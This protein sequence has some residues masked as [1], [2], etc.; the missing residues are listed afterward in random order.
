[1][2][3]DLA[4]SLHEVR[5]ADAR[6]RIEFD[7]RVQPIRAEAGAPAAPKLSEMK[8]IPWPSHEAPVPATAMPD[9]ESL[10]QADVLIVTWTTAEV[11]TLSQ[12]LTPGFE[13]YRPRSGDEK[14]GIT[15]WQKYVKNY[16]Q[17]S[18]HMKRSAPA[19]FD[20]Q[21]LGTY[22]TA[23]VGHTSVT[24]F[25]SDSHL[26]QDG[27]VDLQLSPNRAVWKQV[28]AD[29]RPKWVI[30]T[31]TGGGIGRGSDLG[32]VVISRF[33]ALKHAHESQPAPGATF[34]CPQEAP[35]KAA[36]DLVPLL[37]AN[38]DAL[39]P[40]RGQA[41][42]PRLEP[43]TGQGNGVLTTAGF[44]FDDS[45]N[46]DLLEG[47]GLVCDMGDAMLGSVCQEMGDG[48]PSYVSVRNVSDPQIASPHPP[49][50]SKEELKAEHTEAGGIYDRW[51]GWTTVSSAIACWSIA[52]AAATRV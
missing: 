40:V 13:G 33:I 15:Y 22:W 7:P 23:T 49:P 10:P 5:I 28:L 50:L 8:P 48:A 34:V 14:P 36:G 31:G 4:A 9:G 47:N 18:G 21:R 51:G 37:S 52:A 3:N 6:A 11:I 26:S 46:T 16:A 25:K 45:A 41:G 42:V 29:V 24:L 17:L 39:A 38:A 2:S 1:M 20:Y 30:T 27:P 32:D 44:G 43:A 35:S 12:I 19:V